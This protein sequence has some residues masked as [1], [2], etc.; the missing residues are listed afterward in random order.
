MFIQDIHF[1]AKH[2]HKWETLLELDDTFSWKSKYNALF[3]CTKDSKLLWLE[4]RIFHSIL[5]TNKYLFNCKI[6]CNNKCNLCTK[7]PESIEHLFF[8]CHKSK[9]LWVRLEHFLSFYC[10]FDI[11]FS[12]SEVIFGYTRE[13][14]DI[15]NILISLTKQYIFYKS[16]KSSDLHIS[17][18]LKSILAYYL[19][20]KKLFAIK[21]RCDEFITRWK[22]IE[23]LFANIHV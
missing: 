19:V 14:N 17:E 21:M 12:L 23:N 8:Y 4:Y 22:T 13:K 3:N 18:L 15:V 7:E 20:E 2:E 11:N 1:C 9:Q 16:R 6:T 5:G 10:H